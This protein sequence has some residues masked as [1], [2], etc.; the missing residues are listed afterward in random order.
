MQHPHHAKVTPKFCKQYGQ[1]GIEIERALTA[2][3]EEVKTRQFPSQQ[4][5]P[6]KISGI[7]QTLQYPNPGCAESTTSRLETEEQSRD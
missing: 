6:Y 4:F 5:S 3:N 2:Y 1:I 7:A